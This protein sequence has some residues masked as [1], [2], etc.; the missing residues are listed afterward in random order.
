MNLEGE[1][2]R[3]NPKNIQIMCIFLSNSK[4]ING[5]ATPFY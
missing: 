1:R 2:L 3:F 4:E 5:D